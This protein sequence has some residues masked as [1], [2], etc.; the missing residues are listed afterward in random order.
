MSVPIP[1][2][3][4]FDL[5]AQNKCVQ[6]ESCYRKCCTYSVGIGFKPPYSWLWYL[7]RSATFLQLAIS[8]LPSENKLQVKTEN[9]CLLVFTG[10]SPF[11]GFSNGA[12][13]SFSIHSL[14]YTSLC[15]QLLSG[16]SL[17]GKPK[18]PEISV[19]LTLYSS[20]PACS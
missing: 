2:K 14:H 15:C 3:P 6:G 1:L 7:L 13:V 16:V 12:V 20:T 4:A 8:H 11:Q 19:R 9:H 17:S 5:Q 18:H 10:E